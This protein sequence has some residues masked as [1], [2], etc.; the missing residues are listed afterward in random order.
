[1]HPYNEFYDGQIIID[2][3]SNIVYHTVHTII[4]NY[5]VLDALSLSVK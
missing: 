4:H 2:R 3:M 5:A 1:M